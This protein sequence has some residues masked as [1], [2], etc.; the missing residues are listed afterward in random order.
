MVH[1]RTHYKKTYQTY[2]SEASKVVPEI[3]SQHRGLPMA[4]P[5]EVTVL[6]VLPRPRTSKLDFPAPDIDNFQKAVFDALNTHAWED[7][8]QIIKVTAE[9]TW[10]NQPKGMTIVQVK[11]WKSSTSLARRA[12]VLTT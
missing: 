7:D 9:K 4:G 12:G 5:L 8:K 1:T 11:P 6:F 2:R 3:M 10:T